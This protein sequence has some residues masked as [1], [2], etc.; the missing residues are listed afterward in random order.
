MT[1]MLRVTVLVGSDTLVAVATAEPAAMPV[2][3]PDG[4]MVALVGSLIDQVTAWLAPAGL[5]VAVSCW[6][7]ATAID[8]EAG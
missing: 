8:T 7:A 3:R 2:T 4:E 5:T 6:V 1:V